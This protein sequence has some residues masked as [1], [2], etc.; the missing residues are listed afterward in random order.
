MIEKDKT[1]STGA[2]FIVNLDNNHKCEFVPTDENPESAKCV[3]CG[4]GILDDYVPP[5][6]PE[7]KPLEFI[8]YNKIQRLDDFMIEKVKEHG[9][10][11]YSWV[12]LNKY[13]GGN[14]SVQASPEEVWFCTRSGK[15][16]KEEN[17]FNFYDVPKREEFLTR[18]AKEIQSYYG[19]N[20]VLYFEYFGGSYNHPDVKKMPDPR[21]QKGVDYCPHHDIRLIDIRVDRKYIDYDEMKKIGEYHKLLVA[22]EMMRGSFYDCIKF[23]PA[24]EDPTYKQYNLPKLENN[25]SEGVVLKPTT[26]LWFKNKKRCILKNKNPKFEEKQ[27]EP[28][29]KKV[30]KT[31]TPE[32]Q[33]VLDEL[34]KCITQNRFD[35]ILSHGIEI[36]TD[37]DF[38]K[39]M[40]LFVQDI[41]TE[42]DEYIKSLYA[43]NKVN[44][45]DM[46]VVKKMLEKEVANFIRP[47]I[48]E[49]IRKKEFEE[50]A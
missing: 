2:E 41:I 21:I 29:V 19:K 27:R 28:R 26:N 44:D 3:H 20:I 30:Q 47:K 35:N 7:E 46:K 50:N 14:F 32:L 24:F 38:P 40:G 22:E 8:K 33:A 39:V 48:V 45:D 17:H 18:V 10:D 13:H 15:F 36:K 12:V 16:D 34:T 31:M 11:E 42:E 1:D 6:P 23:D 43:E 4:K 37:K 25:F 49:I 5:E 9:Y